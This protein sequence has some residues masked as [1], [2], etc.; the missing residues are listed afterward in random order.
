MNLSTNRKIGIGV[1]ILLLIFS[2]ILIWNSEKK[3]DFVKPVE[4]KLTKVIINEALRTMLYLPLYHAKE[5][6][7]FEQ[8]GLDVDI[9][10]GGT[11]TNSFASMLSGE[12]DFSQADPMYVPIANEKGG[13]TKVVAQVV[14]RI[15]VWGISMDSTIQKMDKGSLRGKKIS[16]H[17]R[18]MTAYTYTA[19]T[20]LDN[21]LDL[22]EVEIIESTPG[23]EIVPLISGN[24]DFAMTLEPNVS[25]AVSKGAKVVL[26]Y[27]EILGD[28]IF[29]GLMAKDEYIEKNPNIV[30]AVVLS[31]QQAF[32]DIYKDKENAI[33]TS[34]KY[35]PQLE[36]KV[37]EMAVE[38]MIS[39]H[40]I[41]KSVLV[42]EE[43]WN[44][45]ID[46]RVKIGDLKDRTN[47]KENCALELMETVSPR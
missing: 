28:Q 24:S 7:Y 19:K 17:P 40:V 12:A 25:K 38:R 15:A 32:D 20:I 1:V 31:Y 18:P 4:E 26:S 45:A 30:K 21:G 46:V 42:S 37:I 8:N 14:A 9:V 44:K 13:N 39:D 10:T 16:T 11:A 29:T 27:P 33:K 41:P 6:G 23:T 5:V 35:F 22:N 43:S 3:N 36:D 47:R 2:F 34:K